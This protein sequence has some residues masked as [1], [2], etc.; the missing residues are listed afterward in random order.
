MEHLIDMKNNLFC[1]AVHFF[2][3]PLRPKYNTNHHTL[4]K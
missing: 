2:L 3:L 4:M 1:F